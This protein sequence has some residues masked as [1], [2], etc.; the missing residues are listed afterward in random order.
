MGPNDFVP[1]GCVIKTIFAAA[2]ALLGFLA[3]LVLFL[4]TGVFAS[5]LAGSPQAPAPA[6]V[7]GAGANGVPPI[8][9]RYFSGGSIQANVT[10]DFALATNLLVDRITSYVGNDG[11][12]WVAFG[13][14][15]G[16]GPPEVLITFNEPEDTVM[17]A[18]GGRFA[19]GV[20]DQCQFDVQVTASV[21][22]G[23]ISCPDATVYTGDGQEVG[24]SSIDVTFTAAS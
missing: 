11:L 7:T 13:D 6:P 22:S 18:Q 2:I 10:G 16:Q 12:A 3:L 1:R 21:V 14:E 8:S 23:H 24:S 19:K 20:D 15:A 4:L 5:P 17:V 9:E